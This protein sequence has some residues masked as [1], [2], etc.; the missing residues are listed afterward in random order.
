MNKEGKTDSSGYVLV[1]E[2]SDSSLLPVVKS[3]L[4]AVGIS[5]FVQ[6]EESLGMLPVGGVGG[7][8]S[9]FRKGI[10]AK[11]FVLRERREEVEN[12]IRESAIIDPTGNG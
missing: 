5:Y 7:I 12:L 11:I 2:T 3:L 9:T 4:D 8:F 6:G 1:W 10:T